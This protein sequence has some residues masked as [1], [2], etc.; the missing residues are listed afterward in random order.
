ML[1]ITRL[2]LL[3]EVANR[4]TIAATADAFFM[5]PSA[6]SQQLAVLE[7]EANVPLLKKAGRGV[8]LTTAGRALVKNSEEI[9]AAIERAEAQLI[10]TSKGL[11]GSVKISAF[12][13]SQR[14]VVVP[15]VVSLQKNHPNLHLHIQDL[16]PEHSLP[17]LGA[18]DLDIVVYYEWNVLPTI[19]AR[20]T[21][22]YPLV[23]ENVYLGMP[24]THALAKV[25][26]SIKI[27]ELV[28]ENWIVGRESTSMLQFVS[29]AT[30]QAGFS[31]HASFQSMD[32][33]VI[34][35][36]VEAGLGIALVPPL[37]FMETTSNKKKVVYKSL[38]ELSLTRTTKVAVRKGSE[39]NPLI[40]EVLSTLQTQAHAVQYELDVLH[41]SLRENFLYK[42]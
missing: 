26:R 23:T 41:T 30:A 39:F 7:R 25:R 20:G 5:T 16:E 19:P 27:I 38:A 2:Q 11:S 10:D 6:V 9:F 8:E 29:A 36:A 28:D 17:M 3:R 34:L 40:K 32:F 14:S 21:Q 24:A 12:P 18:G 4:K 42:R 37:A 31:P 33:D 22:T 15:A 35:A 13:T 1:N